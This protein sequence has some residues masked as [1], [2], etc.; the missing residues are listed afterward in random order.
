MLYVIESIIIIIIILLQYLQHS[1]ELYLGYSVYSKGYP[2][3]H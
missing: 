2:L 1:E 3:S